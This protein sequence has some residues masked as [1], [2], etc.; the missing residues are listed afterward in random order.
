MLGS[1]S[2]GDRFPVATTQPSANEFVT[3]E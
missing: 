1:R 2:Y 3:F